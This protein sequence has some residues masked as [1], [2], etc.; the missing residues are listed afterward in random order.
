MSAAKQIGAPWKP[1]QSG[2]PGGRKALPPE[3]RGIH[4]LTQLEVCALV[5]KYARMS[6]DELQ[7]AVG[8]PSTPML[9][10]AIASIFAQAAKHGDFARLAFLLDRAIGKVKVVEESDQ[11]MQDLAAK[12]TQELL[13]LVAAKMPLK[14]G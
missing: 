14:V 4:A 11:A 8:S 10:I 9:E 7:A 13:E 5:S 6:R 1:G 2:N 12:S 3:L